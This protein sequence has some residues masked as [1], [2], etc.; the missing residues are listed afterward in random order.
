MPDR[1]RRSTFTLAVAGVLAFALA[2]P[3]AADDDARV[4]RL[5]A[6]VDELEQQ[7]GVGELRSLMPS[8][9]N[10]MPDFSERFHVMHRAGDAGDWAVAQ[11]ELLE[12]RRI[13]DMAR[14]I[15][16]KK[17][18]MMKDFMEAPFASVAAAIEHRDPDRF[19][20]AL[21]TTLTNC[22]ACH[23]AAGSPFINVGLNAGRSVS[24]RHAHEFLDTEPMT[25]HTHEH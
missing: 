24:M 22:N 14:V 25:E 16:A 5:E 7:V 9:T 8:M 18:R 13:M 2:R 23:T 21:E 15:D 4:A 19:L 10:I 6:R 12:M 11:H 20:Q 17:G 1:N 3:V